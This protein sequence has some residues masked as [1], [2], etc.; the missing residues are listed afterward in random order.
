MQRNGSGIDSGTGAS[1]LLD[2]HAVAVGDIATPFNWR[3]DG[4]WGPTTP[5]SPATPTT[6]AACR[7][8]WGTWPRPRPLRAGLADQRSR[9]RPRP[10]EHSDSR[11]RPAWGWRAANRPGFHCNRPGAPGCSLGRRDGWGLASQGFLCVSS[12]KGWGS[13]KHGVLL[14]GLQAWWPRT[15]GWSRGPVIY[16]GVVAHGV[17]RPGGSTWMHASSD[18]SCGKWVSNGLVWL[19]YP[20]EPSTR[21]MKQPLR[22]S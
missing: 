18:S 16:S 15:R 19:G 17:V 5:P 6:S 7:W 20:V 8:T 9:L 21:P 4:P 22:L 3:V 1:E 11:R 12:M 10:P 13:S 2:G 14:V